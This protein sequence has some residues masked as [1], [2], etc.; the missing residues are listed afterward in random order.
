MPREGRSLWERLFGDH[1]RGEQEEEVLRYIIHRL[2]NGAS[3]EETV[4]DNY[5]RRNLSQAEVDE[6][7][8][9][10]ELVRTVRERLESDFESEELRPRTFPR[11]I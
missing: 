1:P 6:V 8:N 10:P 11:R 9:D 2:Q 5:V 7:I 3:L 4:R